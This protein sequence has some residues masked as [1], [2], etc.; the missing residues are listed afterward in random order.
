MSFIKLKLRPGSNGANGEVTLETN[1][2][3]PPGYANGTKWLVAPA[4]SNNKKYN[5]I[6]VTIKK[7]D[8]LLQIFIDEVKI[9]EYPK[10]VPAA[11]L[12]NA[13]SFDCSGNSAE[14]DK[15]FLSNIKILK[16]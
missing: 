8:E 16:N 10:A 4:F 14:N 7:I 11:T 5:R 13:L 15:Y 6:A 9:A 3:S 12:F 2:P 1:F